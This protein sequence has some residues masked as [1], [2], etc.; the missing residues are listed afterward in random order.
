MPE[1]RFSMASLRA[2]ME[3]GLCTSRLKVSMPIS[4]SSDM[5]LEFRAVAK[6]RRPGRRCQLMFD[7]KPWGLQ[8]NQPLE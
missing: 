4:L 1:V 2:E 6:T 5:V 3:A 8:L 7:R